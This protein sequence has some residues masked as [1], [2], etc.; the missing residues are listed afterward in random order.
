ML[1]FWG[2]K[3]NYLNINNVYYV[4]CKHQYAVKVNVVYV[5][6]YD[7]SWCSSPW[8]NNVIENFNRGIPIVN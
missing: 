6:A 8:H 7:V 2:I 4:Y 3:Q 5:V 1:M